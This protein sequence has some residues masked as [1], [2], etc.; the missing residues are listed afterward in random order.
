MSRTTLEGLTLNYRTLLFALCALLLV[1]VLLGGVNPVLGQ[2]ESTV[3]RGEGLTVVTR[4]LQNG[5]YGDP[6]PFQRVELF[7]QSYD[8]LLGQAITD[9]QGYASVDWIPG[10]SHPLGTTLLNVT[11]RGNSSLALSPCSQWT[12]VVVLS[13]TTMTL[14]ANKYLL[15]PED[16]LALTVLLQDDH[17][18]PIEGASVCFLAQ[19]KVIGYSLTNDTGHAVVVVVCDESWCTLGANEVQVTYAGNASQYL[20]PAETSCRID[21]E[22]IPTS[23]TS[24]TAMRDEVLLND[25]ISV[26]LDADSIPSQDLTIQLDGLGFSVV[27]TNASGSAILW[28]HLSEEFSLG[29]HTLTI[30]FLGTFRYAPSALDLRFCVMSPLIAKISPFEP[31][32]IGANTTFEIELHDI[33]NRSI[34]N[35]FLNLDDTH[36]GSKTLTMVDEH[37]LI[38]KIQLAISGEGGP[39]VLRFSISGSTYLTNGTWFLNT[40]SWFLP[41]IVLTETSILGY[42][43]PGQE[44]SLTASVQDLEGAC[45]EFLVVM[46][47]PD[48]ILHTSSTDANGLVSFT[49]I[50][51]VTEGNYS[52]L[53]TSAASTGR[54]RLPAEAVLTFVVSRLMPLL[55]ELK[56]YSVIS[57]MQ[58]LYVVLSL[59]AL[60]GSPVSLVPFHYVWLSFEALATVSPSGLVE[61]RLAV[62]P[63][64]GSYSIFYTVESS[65]SI[66]AASGSVVIVILLEQVL[67]SQGVGVV[68]YIVC[69]TVSISVV[70]LPVLRK[71]YLLG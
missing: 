47:E 14:T 3:C 38:T 13:S 9:S 26:T 25:T 16:H 33:L 11:F 1:I 19:G 66:M 31:L 45:S 40:S 30:Q 48:G 68:G 27:T 21:I 62:P 70:I 32:V 28:L 4:L 43:S 6:V 42:A 59:T 24:L 34:H 29:P 57:P 37:S 22:R 18:N 15:A 50:A 10:F 60:N 8:A 58:Q 63:E 51:P 55:V 56:H 61:L 2:D 44:V 5:S 54:Y 7:D 71:R 65:H 41:V 69:L 36:S 53:L 39:R 17:S 23:I 49:L 67:A 20:S 46:T 52:F 12:T 35:A 64:P